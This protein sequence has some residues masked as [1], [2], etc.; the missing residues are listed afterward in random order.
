MV[1]F[2]RPCASRICSIFPMC[3]ESKALVKSTNS[4]VGFLP[5]HLQGFYGW[6]I[7]VRLWIYFFG[8][9]FGFSKGCCLFWVLCGFEVGHCRFWLLWMYVLYLRSSWLIRGH[10]FRE[11]KDASL[12]PSYYPILII[13]CVALSEQYVV[14]LSGLPY[15]WGDLVMPCSFPIFNF[16]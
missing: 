9:H 5:V 7:F 16:S 14:A 11:R 4:N 2:G 3:M 12:H 15:F 13:D 8:S 6:S 10:L 1:S